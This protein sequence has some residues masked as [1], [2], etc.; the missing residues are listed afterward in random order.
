MKLEKMV[1]YGIPI[2]AGLMLVEMVGVTFL[3]IV[4]REFFNYSIN[5]SDEITQFC[6]M[7]MTFI[8]AIWVTKHERHINTGVKFHSKLN[9]RLVFLIDSFL[10]LV[11]VGIAA[12]VAYQNVIF[13]IESMNV[14]SLAIPGLKMG[15]VY[16]VISVFMLAVSYFYTKRFFKDLARVFKK[17][18]ESAE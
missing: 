15:W 13:S 3:Q 7:W 1:N 17:E 10:A 18:S 4:S 2:F 6:M 11:I 5:W 16:I 8:G 9:Q 14:D 12:V